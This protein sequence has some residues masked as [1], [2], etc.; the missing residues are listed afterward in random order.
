MKKGALGV[1]VSQVH[2]AVLLVEVAPQAVLVSLLSRLDS[3]GANCRGHY[4]MVIHLAL[5]PRS[6]AHRGVSRSLGRLDG[7]AA[8]P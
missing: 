7:S 5:L 8:H 4:R 2:I 6:A 3:P 1:Q